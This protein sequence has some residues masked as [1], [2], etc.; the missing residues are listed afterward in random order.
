MTRLPLEHIRIIDLTQAWA[1]SYALQLLGDFGAEV[2]KVESRTRPDPW[3]GGFEAGRGLA[4]YP[5]SGPGE[6]PYNRS[7]LAN[8]VNRNKY[9]ITLDLSTGEGRELFLDLVRDADVVAENFTPRVLTNLGIGFEELRA[10]QPG[11]ILLSM[12]AFGLSGP[13]SEYPGIGGTIEPMSGNASLLGEPG[14]GAQVSGVMYPDAVAGL[15][16]AA[17]V[18]AALHARDATGE[19]KHVEVSQHESM[20]AMLGEFFAFEPP[21]ARLGNLDLDVAVQ[22]IFPAVGEDQWV[23]I[24]IRDDRD[25]GA[26]R[27][28]ISC[29]APLLPQ[30]SQCPEA[31]AACAAI[32]EWT[33]ERSA[34][35]LVECLQGLDLPAAKVRSIAEVLAC[36]QLGETGHWVHVEQPEGIGAIPMP[37]IIANLHD[38]PGGVRLP[39]VRH[40]EHS[41]EILEKR[42]GLTA[43]R[44]ADLTARGITGEGPPPA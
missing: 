21:P 31:L 17:A 11:I 38:T 44:I 5:V 20:I 33:A 41:A 1:G 15:N 24:T 39:P 9:G 37:G 12:P 8:S 35:E 30:S 19:G 6:R 14:G 10:V 16:G 18:L 42:L 2:I 36:P 43:E 25:W 32:A 3:R 26:L 13:Y 4:A 40:G 27:G 29:L 22:G 7:Y 28:L 34:H 23:S